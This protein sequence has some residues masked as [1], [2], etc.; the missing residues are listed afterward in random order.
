MSESA[1]AQLR[2]TLHTA[3]ANTDR[4][5]FQT[6]LHNLTTSTQTTLPDLSQ[7][8][9]DLRQLLVLASQLNWLDVQPSWASILKRGGEPEHV[10]RPTTGRAF[11]PVLPAQLPPPVVKMGDNGAGS[12]RR[13]KWES[14][15]RKEED[16]SSVSSEARDFENALL[17]SMKRLGDAKPAGVAAAAAFRALAPFLG[18]EECAVLQREFATREPTQCLR[19]VVRMA[20][21][22]SGRYGARERVFGGV[23]GS[24]MGVSTW[25]DGKGW[26]WNDWEGDR[27]N[28][29]MLDVN[30]PPFRMGEDSA[31]GG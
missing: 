3:I 6:T 10:Y 5:L 2:Q 9:P 8:D 24:G 16:T 19:M 18:S 22:A 13:W 27:A 4:A 28:G 25:G 31:R 1:L 20:E 23:W 14:D 30:A 21:V 11:I 7:R 26:G 17:A 12:F 29:K 15:S